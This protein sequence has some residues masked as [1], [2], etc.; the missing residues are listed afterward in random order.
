VS[1]PLGQLIRRHWWA[2]VATV[3]RLTGD[4]AAAEDAVQDACVAALEQWPSAGVPDNA[5]GWLIGVAR[6]K[7]VDRL[8]RE[9]ARGAKE[10]ASMRELGPGQDP[11]PRD[12]DPLSLVFMCCH[13]ALG[14]PARVALTLRSVCGLSTA[15]IAAAFLVPE[16]TMAKRLV[17][18]KAK[19]REAG[20][21]FRVPGPA[22]RPERLAA[23]LRVIYL[24]FTEGHMATGGADLV[25]GDLCD[26]AISL[27]RGV[28]GLLPGE[29]EAMGLLALLLL[30]DARRAARADDAGDLVL[31]EDQDRSRWD[32]AM[33]A[34]GDAVLEAALRLGRPGPYQLHAAIAACHSTAP[35]AGET[36]WRQIA[37]LYAELIRHEPTPVAEANRA[38][39]VAMAEGPAAGLVILDALG[40]D[41]QLRR[42]PQLHI[43]RAELLRR[44]GRGGDAAGAYRAAL[45]L[46]PA[47][48]ARA[49]IARR[50]RGG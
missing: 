16:E 31:L 34:E 18:A 47:P 33:I 19:I 42:W 10:A 45:E 26:A 22:E 7:A 35:S 6:H 50:L 24:L 40:H 20:I 4:L 9:A 37:L 38:V 2:A 25:R 28:S 21:P 39:A 29:A 41:P 27:A 1:D 44:L 48:A 32:Q 36:D 12:A 14:P 8:R 13:P 17:R 3:C 15:Q 43:A 49:F 23:V 11:A 30:T 46:E 5:L